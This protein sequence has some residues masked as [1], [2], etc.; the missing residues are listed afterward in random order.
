MCGCLCA[1]ITHT[2]SRDRA[3]RFYVVGVVVV[4]VAVVLLTM[5]AYRKRTHFMINCSLN[6]F[7]SLIFMSLPSSVRK[8]LCIFSLNR[9]IAYDN[10]CHH[11]TTNI[12][13]NFVLFF[14]ACFTTWIVLIFLLYLLFFKTFSFRVFFSHFFKTIRYQ[15]IELVYCVVCVA[16]WL[17]EYYEKGHH[18]TVV[19][20]Q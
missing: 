1:C 17:S 20:I 7:S 15:Q 12:S 10:F 16:R 18:Y 19:K 11:F 5:R 3:E 8:L 14:S 13:R 4:V 9:L 6:G 2:L